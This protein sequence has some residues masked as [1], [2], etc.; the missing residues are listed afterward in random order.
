[1]ASHLKGVKKSTMTN[2]IRRELCEYK[3]QN[4]A[5]T[6]KQLQQW[7]LE[8]F[9]LQ[10]SQATISNTIKRSAEYLSAADI[11]KDEAKR[12]KAAKFPKL[13]K[14]LFEW[15]IHYQERVNMN[16]ELIRFKSRHG[17]KQYRRFRESGSV[18]ME[19]MESN[20]QS[21]REKLDQFAKKDVFNMD[22]TGLF[23]R[24]QPDHCLATKQLEGKKQDKE[25]LIVV[26]CCNE[27]GSEKIPLWIIRKYLKPRCFKNVNLGSVDCEYRAN[28]RAWMTRI[29]FQE[30]VQQLDAKMDGIIRAFK[31]HYRRRFYR[32]L[33]EGYEIGI[34]NPKKINVLDA[35]NLAISAWK[36][37]VNS[38]TIANCFKHFK[39][40]LLDDESSKNQEQL[41]ND[42]LQQLQ[43]L[44]NGLKYR[45]A[46]NAKDVLN[47][48]GENDTSFE[49]PTDEQIIESVMETHK[50][51][52][53]EDD[54]VELEQVS[55]KDA[56]KATITLHHFLLQ[57]K[58][59]TPDILNAVRRVRD[60]IQG[61]ID[62][63]KK[64]TTLDSY[65]QKPV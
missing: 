46:M 3:Q 17:I 6:Q 20:L 30:Y 31:M 41:N 22:E 54:S 18:T 53:V 25:R 38:S 1:M 8:K 7:V 52:E 12:H 47:Y 33:L 43:N 51:D 56:L 29:L 65:F 9:N 27:D 4:L 49:L 32:N 36:I 40:R 15:F 13:E 11:P 45:N 39:L 57:Y 23:F 35:M 59:T 34:S 50:E 61:D 62:F 10:V 24:L 42:G 48:P 5:C 55:R 26:I 58:K 16:G 19:A 14:S 21:I 37:D 63:K 2:G 28:K 44:I 60:E 64:Q